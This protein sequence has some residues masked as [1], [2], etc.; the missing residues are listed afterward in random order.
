M[1]TQRHVVLMLVLALAGCRGDG[2]HAGSIAAADI[3]AIKEYDRQWLQ[4]INTGD[5]PALSALTADDHI[6]FPPNGPPN[7]GKAAN[8]KVNARTFEQYTVNEHWFPA[9]LVVAG[10]WG[11]ERGYFTSDSTPKAGGAVQRFTGYY[12]RILRRQADGSWKMIREMASSDKPDPV[13]P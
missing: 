6:T 9:D 10:D 11:Y 5:M 8:D 7:V 3:A 12:L 13:K 4:A 1:N 2:P